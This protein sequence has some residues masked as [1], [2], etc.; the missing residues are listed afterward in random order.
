MPG[1]WNLVFSI[2][3]S[4]RMNIVK[5]T[6]MSISGKFMRKEK[7]S[8]L[9]AEPEVS[10]ANSSL[11]GYLGTQNRKLENDGFTEFYTLSMKA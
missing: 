9:K 1:K 10:Q 4:D 2:V 3:C 6:G 5:K 8:L 11:S 7:L